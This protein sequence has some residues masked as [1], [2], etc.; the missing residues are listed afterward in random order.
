MSFIWPGLL[1]S[2]VLVPLLIMIYL[3]L[4]RRRKQLSA[5]YGKLGFGQAG[6]NKTP[7]FRRHVPPALFICSFAILMVA[8]ARP[9]T[10]VSLPRVQGTVILAF[11]VSGSMGANDLKPTRMEAA[12][13]A[14]RD[15]VNQQPIDVQI[16]VVAFSDNGFSVQIPTNDKDVVLAAI[17][18]LSPQRGTSLGNGINATIKS[19]ITAAAGS[20]TRFYSNLTPEPTPS[21]T[22]VPKG[23]YT[24]AAVVLLTDGEN[25]ESPDP[26]AAAQVAAD[27]GIR[28][29]TIGIGSA[30]GTTL[31]VNGFTVST[32]LNEAMLKQIAQITGGEYYNATTE[33]DLRKI[34]DNITPQMQIKPEETEVTSLFAGASIL[35]MLT[36]A[37]FS[38]VW[39][40]RLP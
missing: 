5:N 7:G 9:Q 33:Q 40:S 10:T 30:A 22:P 12:K 8:L 4:Q 36:G 31:H 2:L 19:I 15:F 27:R 1:F 38:L 35:V 17:N 37:L 14:A 28:I 3:L 32:R 29:Y 39:F 13:T 23:S 34:Y 20:S 18:R 16:G 25:N 21:P 11:D 26:L 24:S 6:A